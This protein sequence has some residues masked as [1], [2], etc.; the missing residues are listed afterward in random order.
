MQD[1]ITHMNRMRILLPSFFILVAAFVFFFGSIPKAHALF[2]MSGDEVTALQAK[3]ASFTGWTE[4]VVNGTKVYCSNTST[5]APPLPSPTQAP[6]P[7]LP[8]SG[9]YPDAFGGCPAGARPATEAE[10]PLMTQAGIPNAKAGMCWNPT[11]QY[12][13]KDDAE[14]KKYLRSI[15]C[16][17]SKFG[18]AGAD[19]TV[20]KLDSKFA[21]CAAKFLKAASTQISGQ[22]SLLEGGTNPVCLREGYRTPEQQ[23]IYYQE[24]LNGGGIACGSKGVQ[25]CEHPRGIAIDVNTSGD[26]N[27]QRLWAL[28]PQYS[29]NFYLRARDKVHFVPLKGECSG[30]GT[31]PAG[32]VMPLNYHDFPQYYNGPASSTQ[33]PTTSLLNGL[34]NLLGMN[35]QPTPQYLQ[36]QYTPPPPP[37]TQTQ[38][39]APTYYD[40]N[41][42]PYTYNS[43]GE[44]ISSVTGQPINPSQT[45]SGSQIPTLGGTTVNN[46]VSSGQ[47]PTLTNPGTFSTTSNNGGAGTGNADIDFIN[48]LATSLAPD[49]GGGKPSGTSTP[50]Q[51]NKNLQNVGAQ[52]TQYPNSNYGNNYQYPI[53]FPPEVTQTFGSPNSGDLTYSSDPA[54]P[55]QRMLVRLKGVLGMIS[56]LLK[57]FGRA[58]NQQI[59]D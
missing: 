30:G 18:G 35:Q 15:L 52:K 12:V 24:Y 39:T 6:A 57:P 45:N 50:A 47:I 13:G 19:G 8:T 55:F 53:V 49:D 23:Q 31:V 17:G 29:V 16:A 34:R 14:A 41:G 25:N 32:G 51:L 54:S 10:V 36:P 40:A 1:I 21:I 3:G 56:N 2:C 43:A 28:G 11:D 37:P 44:A 5:Q 46:N 48:N 7:T 58:Q 22:V 27:Y 26:A 9:Q 59:I 33:S 38:S 4:S 42:Q 20:Q